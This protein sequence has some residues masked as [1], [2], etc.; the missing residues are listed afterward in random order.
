MVCTQS[1]TNAMRI[2]IAPDKFKGSLS[3]REVCEAIKDGLGAK[4]I[5]LHPLADGGDGSLQV[6]NQHLKL[7]KQEIDTVDPLG[8][9]IQSFYYTEQQT[10]F[11]EVAKASGLVLLSHSERNPMETSTYGTGLMMAKAIADGCSHIYLFLGG[12]ATNDGGIG[13]AKALGATF[14]DEKSKEL[15]PNGGQLSKISYYQ[16]DHKFDRL[17]VKF[18]LLCDVNNPL[19]GPQ[20]ASAVY[21]PQKGADKDMIEVLDQGL[22]NY[23]NVLQKQTGIEVAHLPGSG[24]AGGIGASM[25]ALFGAEL[26]SGIETITEITSLEDQIMQAD[27]VISGEGN[28][29]SQSLQG[30]V[31]DGVAQLCH[32]H[33]KPLHLFVGKNDLSVEESAQVGAQAI[34]AI[35]DQATDLPDAMKNGAVYLKAMAANLAAGI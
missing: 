18:T 13:I 17:K 31:V 20:G 34:S 16:L 23:A 29:D 22:T 3:S 5:K 7:T 27:L 8:R 30:K 33:K 10:A 4:N 26:K 11:I 9:S 2:L 21:A 19:V 1:I 35:M 14:F 6:L 15:Q 28:L 25:I 24:A 32:K 12:S